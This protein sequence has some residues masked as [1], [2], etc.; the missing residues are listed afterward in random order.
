MVMLGYLN[1]SHKEKS[2]GLGVASVYNIGGT[3]TGVLGRVLM[4]T[5]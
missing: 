4:Y 5:F 3:N 2:V 1:R